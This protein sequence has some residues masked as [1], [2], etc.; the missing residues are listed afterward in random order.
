[1][2]Q[3]IPLA[4]GAAA[5]YG[6]GLAIAGTAIAGTFAGTVVTSLAGFAASSIA[7]SLFGGS[8]KSP[9]L[10]TTLNN[11][12]A[13]RA[14]MVRQ[15]ITP[16]SIP[17]G[18]IKTSGP[19]VFMHSQEDDFG[20]TY[21]NLYVVVALAGCK[22]KRIRTIYFGD[23]LA[24]DELFE[25]PGRQIRLGLHLGTDDQAADSD[26]VSEIGGTTWTANHRLRGIAYIAARLTYDSTDLSHLEDIS[27]IIDG[28]D[29]IYDPRTLA[30][31]FSNNAALCIANWLTSPWGRNLAWS[32]LDEDALIEA[33]NICD[34]RVLVR[35][36]TGTFAIE[37]DEGSPAVNEIRVSGRSLDWG[38]GV[39]VSSSGTL[40]TGLSADTTYYVICRDEE[41]IALAS[42]VANAF[43]GTAVVISSAG[44]GTLTITY[45]D[46]ARYKLNG[47]F[48]LDT[49]TGEVLDQM[50]A[51]MAGYVF[52]RGGKWFIHAGAAATPTV[53]LDVDDLAG[54]F[55]VVPKRSM[56]DRING[57]RA[58]YVNPD[59]SW[60]PDDAPVLSPTE[61]LLEEDADEELYGD[62]RFTFVTSGRQV[63]R[64]MKIALER[65]RRQMTAD[66]SWK[67]TAMKLAP[68]DGV[69]ITVDRY[70]TAKQF[71]VDGW[72]FN[73]ECTV[74]L[75]LQEDDADVYAWDFSTDEQEETERSSVTL[76]TGGPEAP[77]D[78][79]VETPE[80]LETINWPLSWTSSGASAYDVEYTTEPGGS[81]YG[82]T[83]VS[84]TSLIL[85]I[86]ETTNGHDFRVRATGVS[87][88]SAYL[89]N[90]APGAPTG[91]NSPGDGDLEWTN[92][93]EAVGVQIF[94]DNVYLQTED[95]TGSPGVN[96]VDGLAAG[97]Y[98][99]RSVNSG[100]NVSNIVGPV[101]VS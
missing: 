22:I 26:F 16:H 67:L 41:R 101:T 68:V 62:Q 79:I 100:G 99:I 32:R 88:T 74:Q 84:A 37:S 94:K 89:E 55:S 63:Q 20:R 9:D 87:G 92:D 51:A 52:P 44:T 58:V 85:T 56:R 64:L 97:S 83:T 38:D 78:L 65:N 40:P 34:E 45:W 69:Y 77:D 2:P 71:R 75:M 86:E 47:S 93:A 76:P 96:M 4:V 30:T 19:L 60:Q 18:R 17:Y 14:T 61:T 35:H 57:V 90:T 48:T 54:D 6:A 42:T 72:R 25:H 33:A 27:A 23:R 31:G 7:G 59:A 82:Y 70:F 95:V 5:S 50:R 24:T 80:T 13:G 1:M 10:P 98:I 66:A 43:A 3:A 12:G 11:S 81:Y 73:P 36:D 8:A 46:E 53:T 15:P 28:V 91:I 21:G 39:R 49:E 29:S